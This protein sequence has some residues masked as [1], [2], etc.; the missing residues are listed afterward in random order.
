M[1]ST[2]NRLL[3]GSLLSPFQESRRLCP[4]AS[5]SQ[6][7]R[8]APSAASTYVRLVVFSCPCRDL[9]QSRGEGNLARTKARSMQQPVL[10]IFSQFGCTNNQIWSNQMVLGRY[11]GTLHPDREE[12]TDFHEKTTP[13]FMRK[14]VLM[15]KLNTM[16]WLEDKLRKS[17]CSQKKDFS[18]MYFRHKSLEEFKEKFNNGDVLSDLPLR[19]MIRKHW[20]INSR[21]HMGKRDPKSILDQFLLIG[22]M[23]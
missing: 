12:S 10:P 21:L 15:Q 5:A 3:G 6:W 13:Y 17:H 9:I 1:S 19:L 23:K 14:M 7:G 18:W 16:S 8:F 11:K 22:R 2:P 4:C 20:W